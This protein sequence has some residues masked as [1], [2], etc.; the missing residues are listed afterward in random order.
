MLQRRA[1]PGRHWVA[2]ARR[3]Y[4]RNARSQ[5][6]EPA[7]GRWGGWSCNPATG[8]QY[9]IAIS[10]RR[11]LALLSVWISAAS[12]GAAHCGSPTAPVESTPLLPL[13]L[14]GTVVLTSVGQTSQFTV[15]TNAGAPVTSGLTWQTSAANV[16]AV[17]A[18]GLVTATGF[19]SATVTATAAGAKGTLSISVVRVGTAMTTIS[20]C[21]AIT[22]PG[23]YVLNSDLPAT[24]TGQCLKL[25]GVSAVQI[26]CRGH[27]VSGVFVSDANTVTISNCVITGGETGLGAFPVVISSG[28]SVTVT[29]CDVTTSTADAIYM[30]DGTNNQVLQS[31]ITGG[32]PGGPAS[33][34]ADDGIQLV[35]ETG[36]IIQGNTI[37]NF[38]DAGIEGADTVANTT[39][40]SN[41]IT[42]TGANGIGTYWCTNWTNNVVRLNNVSQSGVMFYGEYKTDP[43][44]CG[45]GPRRRTL[46]AILSLAID[47]EVPLKEPCRPSFKAWWRFLLPAL[48]C[49]AI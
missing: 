39:F 36:D 20:A 11:R 8:V 21:Q 35:Y 45:A 41:T 26:D 4:L 2:C 25:V 5:R 30:A 40:A 10:Q 28:N 44:K 1:R 48:R 37:S 33:A 22:A 14:Y 27:A 43:T 29:N 7:W 3:V 15:T 34:G 6:E 42:N 47:S 31:T 17:S 32:Y 49:R 19:G 9:G 12:L 24:G 13:L 46:R 18:T 23:S 16:A 38:F